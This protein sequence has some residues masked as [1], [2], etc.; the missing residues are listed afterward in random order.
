MDKDKMET[1]RKW[2]REKMAVKERMNNLCEVQQFLGYCN[3]Y[4]RFIPKY[5]EKVEPLTTLTKKDKPFVWEAEQQLAFEML[6]TAFTT[7]SAL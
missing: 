3:Y 5:S 1:V 7:E 6:G 4:R 2:S